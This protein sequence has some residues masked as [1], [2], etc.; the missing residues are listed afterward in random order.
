MLAF[1]EGVADTLELEKMVSSFRG[2]QDF[3]NVRLSRLFGRGQL[4]LLL[5]PPSLK[6]VTFPIRNTIS[7]RATAFWDA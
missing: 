5:Y 3:E 6:V 2:R 1:G 4:P 7:T